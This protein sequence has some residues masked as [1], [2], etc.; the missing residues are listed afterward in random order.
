M[1]DSNIF[2]HVRHKVMTE[3]VVN[4]KDHH[5]LFDFI[6]SNV[7]GIILRYEKNDQN[8]DQVLNDV[9]LRV[10]EKME[11][12]DPDREELVWIKT[13]ARNWCID[14]YRKK[15]KIPSETELNDADLPEHDPINKEISRNHFRN[16][17]DTI[18]EFLTPK[19]KETLLLRL[20]GYTLKQ[21]A[22]KRGCAPDTVKSQNRNLYEV[23][24]KLFNYKNG[25]LTKKNK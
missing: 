3:Q 22:E 12:F 4:D 10:L 20:D 21:I 11:S 7:Y 1:Q 15:S 23:A 17:I 18:A 16:A 6:R 2:R 5:E 24:N 25:Q 14:L 9:Y 13:V 19:V 8:A